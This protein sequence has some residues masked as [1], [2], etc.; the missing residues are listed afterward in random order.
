MSPWPVV[1]GIE[2]D[3]ET[4]AIYGTYN[5]LLDEYAAK[6]GPTVRPLLEEL[7]WKII[8]QERYG[9]E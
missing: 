1:Y 6:V 4:L 5:Q 8:R 2:T 7:V 3:E 9:D